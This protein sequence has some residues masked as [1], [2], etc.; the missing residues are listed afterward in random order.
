[1]IISYREIII[2][3]IDGDTRNYSYYIPEQWIGQN[4]Y[5]YNSMVSDVRH[6]HRARKAS[7]QWYT[8]LYVLPSLKMLYK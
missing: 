7:L 6:T 5:C 3:I 1:M 4:L 2:E 8:H